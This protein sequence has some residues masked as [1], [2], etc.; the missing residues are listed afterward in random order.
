MQGSILIHQKY[1]HL[2]VT[3]TKSFLYRTSLHMIDELK[4]LN[5]RNM[6]FC[7]V[8]AS[9]QRPAKETGHIRQAEQM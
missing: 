5:H 3:S 7:L 9:L 6:F 1:I 2:N 4:P 8:Y